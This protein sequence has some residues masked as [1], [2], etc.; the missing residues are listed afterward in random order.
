VAAIACSIV[1]VEACDRARRYAA[2]YSRVA[3]T[4]DDVQSC[5]IVSTSESSRTTGKVSQR[6]LKLQVGV[7]GQRE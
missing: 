4:R 2:R 7:A 3:F 1:L 6:A 5:P